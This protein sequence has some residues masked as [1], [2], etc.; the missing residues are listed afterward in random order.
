MKC[1][2][3]TLEFQFGEVAPNL[4]NE[5]AKD[6]HPPTEQA[7]CK[8][9]FMGVD[10]LPDKGHL[11]A[12]ISSLISMFVYLRIGPIKDCLVKKL[13][14]FVGKS[15]LGFQIFLGIKGT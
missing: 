3:K 6:S 8:E 1:F 13:E 15:R 10:K 11:L 12:G 5:C 14:L 7:D 4:Q 2:V 9:L